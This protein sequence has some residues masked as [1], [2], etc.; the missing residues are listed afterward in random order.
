MGWMHDTLDYFSRD[1]IHRRYHQRDITF[2]FLYARSENYLLPLSHDE[3][4]YGKRSLIAKMPGDRWRQFANLR[5]LYAYMW[6]HPGKKLIFMGCEF[7]QWNEWNHDHSLDW[8]LLEYEDHRG[9][10]ALIRTLNH[11]YRNEPALWEA[12]VEPSGFHFIDADNA[13][14]NIVAFL[15]SAPASGRSIICVCNFSPVIREHYRI[16]A[17]AAGLYHEILNTDSAFFGGSNVG[18]QGTVAADRQP[19]HGFDYSLSLTLP[20]LAVIWLEVPQT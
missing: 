3:V 4:V 12:D 1:P 15:R 10:H 18:N 6:A 2:G 17:P 11:I 8:H 13:D 5:A 19:Y 7:A 20:P 14:E 16:G 9:M